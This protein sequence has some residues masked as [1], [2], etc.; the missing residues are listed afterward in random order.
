MESLRRT[1]DW[2]QRCK[3]WA[4]THAPPTQQHFGIVQGS[5]YADLREESA[6][7]LVE[8]DF[9]GYAIGGVS[10]G[11]PEEEMFRAVEHAEPFLPHDKP[12]YAMGLGT[13]PQLV[14][15]IGRGI[16][17]FDCVLPTRL[18][19]H[20][21]ALTHRGPLNL[22]NERFAKDPRPIEENS[23]S[24]PCRKGFSRAYLRHLVKANEILGLRLIS[25]HNL[26][27]YLSL[28]R[29]AREALDTSCFSTFRE[30][31]LNAYYHPTDPAT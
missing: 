24:Y 30:G 11:E 26:H 28:A 31:F 21:T 16:D 17:L 25:L 8:L 22:K 27:F 23:D 5:V 20:G 7:S 13:P 3:N 15:M 29:R 6:H 14:E 2:A 10:V 18:A 1:Q 12:R 9:A 19:R 4:E